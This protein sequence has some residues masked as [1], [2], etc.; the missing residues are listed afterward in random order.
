MKM[1]VQKYKLAMVNFMKG[2]EVFLDD[3]EYWIRGKKD[4]YNVM[5]CRI[6]DGFIKT[7]ECDDMVLPV[8]GCKLMIG[9]NEQCL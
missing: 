3:G 4:G 9:G 5:C 7:F 1:E 2:G 8:N 6:R